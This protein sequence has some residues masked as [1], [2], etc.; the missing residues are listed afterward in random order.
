MPTATIPSPVRL[1][2]AGDEPLGPQRT[3]NTGLVGRMGEHGWRCLTCQ[4]AHTELGIV[5][6]SCGLPSWEAGIAQVEMSILPHGP[7]RRQP[8]VLS[9]PTASWPLCIRWLGRWSRQSAGRLNQTKP[10]VLNPNPWG[11]FTPKLVALESTPS[12]TVKPPSQH[13]GAC[14]NKYFPALR[15]SPCL[16]GSKEYSIWPPDSFEE[17][18]LVFSTLPG[19]LPAVNINTWTIPPG[20]GRIRLPLAPLCAGCLALQCDLVHVLKA[21]VV[22]TPGAV[23]WV[24]A[25]P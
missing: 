1:S 4:A 8:A 22:Y 23:W 6:G 18:G 19:L 2:Q 17:C 9:S 25:S 14:L 5:R 16:M 10:A 15:C 21:G 3:E 24:Q 13:S 11:P 7:T 12:A 20:M